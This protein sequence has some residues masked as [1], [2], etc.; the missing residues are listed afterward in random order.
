[1]VF[2]LFETESHSLGQVGVQW[3]DLHSLQPL[4]PG[5]RRLSWLRFQSSWD[6]RSKPPCPADF[7]F[8][9]ETGFHHVGQACLE[10]L[11][12]GNPPVLAS[13]S[14][15]I[16]GVRHC[17]GQIFLSFSLSFCFFSFFLFFFFFERE[18]CSVAQAEMQWCHLCSL[19]PLSPGFK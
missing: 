1:M 19:E 4:P 14:A 9:V 11:T 7:V 18:F 5:F 3:C 15:G 16:R 13:Q 12:S 17:A 10:L 2:C 6:Y 8:L